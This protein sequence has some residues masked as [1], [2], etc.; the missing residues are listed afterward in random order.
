[1]ERSRRPTISDVAALTGLSK[2]TV[3]RALN[4]RQRVSAATRAR[5]LATLEE[6]GYLRSHAA[7]SLS[8]GRTGLL[9]LVV[10]ANRNPTVLSAMHGALSAAGDHD[11]VVYVSETDDGHDTIYRRLLTSRAVDGVVHLFPRIA[12]EPVVRSLQ[13]AGVPVVLVEPEAAVEGV[14]TVWPDSFD[15]GYVS[16]AHLVAHG[17]SRIAICADTPGWGREQRYVAGYRRALAD[18]SIEFDA[19]LVAEAGWT[20]EAGY[21]ATARWLALDDPPTA[22]C[23]CCDTAAFGAMAC[24]RDRGLRLPEDLAIVGYDDTDVAGWAAP[25]LTALHDRRTSLVAEAFSILNATLAGELTA[26]VDVEVR[27]ELTVR[28]SSASREA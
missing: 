18:A 14:S 8:T 3:S 21:E 7:A 17:H 24:A 2:A 6:I 16:T 15:D 28:A 23:Y 10:G 25:A 19:A 4:D 13:R 27:S 20:H 1:M 26:P 9:G 22:A 5:V 11:V 12:D